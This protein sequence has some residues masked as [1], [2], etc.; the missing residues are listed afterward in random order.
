MNKTRKRITQK[1]NKANERISKIASNINQASQI[2]LA[3]R[4]QRANNV[5]TEN[6]NVSK[7][8]LDRSVK[9][10]ADAIRKY[11]RVIAVLS[12]NPEVQREFADTV[13]KVG[14]AIAALSLNYG[15]FML[16]IL[17]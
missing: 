4:I 8:A 12:K 16:K 1:V 5:L 11:S 10:A 2:P 14:D 15:E 17:V 13:V 3:Q 9:Q 6:R 7:A